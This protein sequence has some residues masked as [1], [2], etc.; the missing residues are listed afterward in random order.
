MDDIFGLLGT[1]AVYGG[2]WLFGY[3]VGKISR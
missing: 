3:I 2:V 1:I